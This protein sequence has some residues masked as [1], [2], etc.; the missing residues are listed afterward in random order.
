PML[1]AFPFAGGGAGFYRSWRRE[2]RDVAEV[3]AA[4]LP[5][6]ETRIRE[7]PRTELE[8]LVRDLVD[9]LPP[10]DRPYALVG[11]SLGASLAFA[12]ALL[13]RRRGEPPPARLILS[14]ASALH[15]RD[16]SDPAHVLGD[17]ALAARL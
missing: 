15:L 13:L 7:A 3:W 6:R 16:V 11:H 14:G 5:G 9:A 8:P 1:I 2:L 17:D 12:V 4:Q 10:L